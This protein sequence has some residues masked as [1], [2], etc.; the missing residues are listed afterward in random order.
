MIRAFKLE[1]I[2]TGPMVY[3]AHELTQ[4]SGSDVVIFSNCEEVRLSW[5][6]KV[7]GTQKPDR[8]SYGAPR[9]PIIFKN[10]FSFHE[11]TQGWGDDNSARKFEMVAE[12]LINGTVVCRQSK[13]YPERATGLRLTL[14]DVG[15]ALAAD[16]SDFVP[17]RATVID[18]KGIPKV[19]SA[20]YVRFE[21]EGAGELIGGDF[22]HA[23]PMKTEMG[24][25]TALIRAGTRPGIIRVRA[26]AEGLAP[27]EDLLIQTIKPGL[28]LLYN[29]ADAA[30]ARVSNASLDKPAATPARASLTEKELRKMQAE[31]QRLKLELTSRDQA[32]MDLRSKNRQ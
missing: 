24:T 11:L 13:K 12:G 4:V 18:N 19:L 22:N 26:T 16:G 10:V 15:I 1:G 32:I 2:Q 3:I 28:A 7:I 21:V 20:E 6:G 5:L 30:H 31:I 8:G 23:N 27:A 29:P 9:P 14:D 17:V 25:A